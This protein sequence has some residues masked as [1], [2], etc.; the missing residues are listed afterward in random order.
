RRGPRARRGPTAGGRTAPAP[1]SRETRVPQTTRERT[2][3]PTLSVPRRCARSG[4]ASVLP[5]FWASGSY[6]A[7]SGAARATATASSMTPAPKGAS[8]ARAARRRTLH[9]IAWKGVGLSRPGRRSARSDPGIDPPI[10]HVDHEVA[11]D[12]ADSDQQ[13]DSLAQRIVPR[14]HR[15]DNEPPHAGKRENVF[16]DD[17]A[18]DQRAELEPEDRHDRDERVAE[19]VAPHDAPLREP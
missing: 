16:R 2:S 6:G 13:H 18:A 14:E 3:R 12:E 9:R 11:H 17:R 1:A 5:R 7:T 10:E 4:R 19:H 8:R 15:V